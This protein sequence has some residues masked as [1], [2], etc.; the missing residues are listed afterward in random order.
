MIETAFRAHDPRCGCATHALP[1]EMPLEVT[2][3]SESVDMVRDQVA[4]WGAA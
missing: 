2:V 3:E 4:R 1:G